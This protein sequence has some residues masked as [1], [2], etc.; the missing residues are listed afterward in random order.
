MIGQEAINRQCEQR[1]KTR[2][3]ERNA[4]IK[5]VADLKQNLGKGFERGFDLT[6]IDSI[7]R[8]A[9]RARLLG[10]FEAAA[11]LERDPTVD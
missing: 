8:V 5:R 3:T 7:K 10:F 11:D 4:K 1:L 9:E 2:K 6:A